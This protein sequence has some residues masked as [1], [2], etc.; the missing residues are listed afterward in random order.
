MF[1]DRNRMRQAVIN[2]LANAI[3]LSPPNDKVR[4]SVS[5]SNGKVE[6]RITD[7][8]ARIS[9]ELQKKIFDRFVQIDSTDQNQ[10]RAAGLSLAITKAIVEQHGGTIGVTSENGNGNIFWFELPRQA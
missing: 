9:D 10:I 7:H 5:S 3:R 6:F 1:A 2:L 8:G 4:L